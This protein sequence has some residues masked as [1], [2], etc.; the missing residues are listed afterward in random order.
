MPNEYIRYCPY[1]G[2]ELKVIGNPKCVTYIVDDRPDMTLVKNIIN[3][4]QKDN[5]NRGIS[6]KELV[7]SLSGRIDEA[8]TDRILEKL[9]TSGEIY[10]PNFK[11]YKVMPHLD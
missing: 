3:K 4:Y 2:S 6:E 11:V 10:S 5:D 7:S 8:S 9:L 1:C